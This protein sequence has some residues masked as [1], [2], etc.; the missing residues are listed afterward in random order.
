MSDKFRCGHPITAE[1]LV[2]NKD[3]YKRCRTCGLA[4]RRELHAAKRAGITLPKASRKRGSVA[5]TER[6]NI[7]GATIRK[8]DFD[9][10]KAMINGSSKLLARLIEARGVAA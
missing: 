3:G 6:Y 10:F 4:R 9:H 7:S 8:Q 5:P 2:I 1:H